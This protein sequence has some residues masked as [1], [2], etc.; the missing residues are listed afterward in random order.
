MRKLALVITF[1]CLVTAISA[2]HLIKTDN[3]EASFFSEAPLENIE[4]VNKNVKAIINVQNGEVAFLVP[5][6]KFNFEKP[7]MQEHFNE[8]YM[9]SHIYPAAQFRGKITDKINFKKD[10]EHE[11]TVKGTLNVHGIDK[12]RE[13]KGKVMIKDGAVSI[14]SEFEIALTDHEIEIPKLVVKKIAETVAV[15]IHASFSKIK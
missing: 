7:L 12:E 11:V 15:K 10:G 9:E 13:I 14:S 3:G 2:Q 4:A 8:N 6:V 5:I 1:F